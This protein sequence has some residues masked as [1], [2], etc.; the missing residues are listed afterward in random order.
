MTL[1]TPSYPGVEM[2][3]THEA[4]SIFYDAER[5]FEQAMSWYENEDS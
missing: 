1:Q 2:L 3:N 4:G 5:L